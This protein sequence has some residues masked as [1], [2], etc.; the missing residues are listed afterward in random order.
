MA[1]TRARPLTTDLKHCTEELL[2][3][4]R[5]TSLGRDAPVGRAAMRPPLPRGVQ[6]RRD[7][8]VIDQ[9]RLP[10]PPLIVQPLRPT[11]EEP[12]PPLA[13]CR[14]HLNWQLEPQVLT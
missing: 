13:Y 2:E 9:A 6:Q 8:F 1:R 4:P 11:F 5:F 3:I 7:R 12:P 14:C 10:G